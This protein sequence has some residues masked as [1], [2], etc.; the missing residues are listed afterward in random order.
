MYVGYRWFD[1]LDVEPLFPFGHG[2]SY[3]SFK[4]DSSLDV[5]IEG[6]S[7]VK[8]RTRVT[9]TGSIAGAAVVQAYVKPPTPTPLT[10]SPS[11]RTT[12]PRKELKGFAKVK[13]EAGATNAV[14]IA[15]D[16]LRATSYWSEMEN[17]WRSE[18]GTY[19]VL[20]GFSSRD[21]FVEQAFEVD[22]SLSWQG[23]RS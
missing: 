13:V 9:N 19:T 3:T 14:E 18:A 5:T 7:A 11:T 21:E 6:G 2:L 1:T 15:V 10:A 4:L 12:R 17:R 8:I 22:R 23:L 20:L 16:L